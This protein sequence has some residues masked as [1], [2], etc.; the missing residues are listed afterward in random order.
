MEES[1]TTPTPDT[2]ILPPARL[3]VFAVLSAGFL[4]WV[5][6]GQIEARVW[7]SG[8]L[9]MLDRRISDMWRYLGNNLPDL[10]LPGFFSMVYWISISFLVVGTIAGLWLFLGTSDD[11]PNPE[12]LEVIHAAHLSHEAE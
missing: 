1:P 11:D 9:T 2:T 7:V 10:P 8:R 3:I 6:Y 12:S 5:A 4:A